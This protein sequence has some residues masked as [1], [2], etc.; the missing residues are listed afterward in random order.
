MRFARAI[1]T[2]PAPFTI[3]FLIANIFVFL[4][5]IM[6]AKSIGDSPAFLAA[7]IA[8]GGKLN[9]LINRGEWWRFVT[10]VFLHGSGL[11]LLMNMYGLWILGPFVERLYGSAKFV[12]FWVLTGVAGV[13]AS[14]LT[15]RPGMQLNAVSRFLFKNVDS[16]SIGA[17]G[18]LFG[19]IGVLFVFGIKFRHELPDGFKRAFGTGMLPTI[20]LNVF[21]G[22][23]IPVID[24][25]AHLGGLVAGAAL[26][27]VV[28]YK[29]PHEPQRVT[30][31]W[32]VLQVAALLLV[33]I[34][35]VMVARHF[36]GTPPSPRNLSTNVLFNSG[37]DTNSYSEAL[38]GAQRVIVNVLK[39]WDSSGAEE[40]A[41]ALEAAPNFDEKADAIR[42]ELKQLLARAQ[43]LSKTPPDQRTGARARALREELAQDL[44]AWVEKRN[45][46]IKSDGEKYG[47]RLVEPKAQPEP[48]GAEPQN[49]NQSNNR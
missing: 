3:I 46:W 35:F 1:L 30:L 43:S 49:K 32:H 34:S 47:V 13:V 6:S 41:K 44:L 20:L 12:F 45:A 38:N 21:I 4:L 22:F 26:A 36:R 28:G 42:N 7:L 29:R 16:V 8:Y 40:A 5:T 39:A 2:R 37:A 9:S 31:F 14:Y 48:P 18:A 19:L 10:P 33:A 23:A 17:S 11:H 15:V 25:A 24:N 27:L